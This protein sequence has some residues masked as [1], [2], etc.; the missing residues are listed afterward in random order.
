MMCCG[1]AGRYEDKELP[2]SP[3][4]E[5]DPRTHMTELKLTLQVSSAFSAKE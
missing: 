5:D 4:P 1:A 2:G 3:L